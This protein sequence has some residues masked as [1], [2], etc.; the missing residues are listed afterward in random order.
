MAGYHSS[1]IANDLTDAIPSVSFSSHGMKEPSVFISKLYKP[2][3]KPLSPIGLLHSE[4][5]LKLPLN[6]ISEF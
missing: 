3:C 2:L 6:Y 4:Q 1:I 5:H